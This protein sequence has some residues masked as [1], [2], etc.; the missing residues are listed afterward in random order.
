MYFLLLLETRYHFPRKP[1]VSPDLRARPLFLH[2]SLEESLYSQEVG[3]RLLSGIPALT[4][5]WGKWGEE[6]M[7]RG[8]VTRNMRI[9]VPLLNHSQA[10]ATAVCGLGHDTEPSVIVGRG[11]QSR[12]NMRNGQKAEEKRTFFCASWEVLIVTEDYWATL[13]FYSVSEN[14]TCGVCVCMCCKVYLSFQSFRK[15]KVVLSSIKKNRAS[16][17]MFSSHF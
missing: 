12:E 2:V 16:S 4:T 11:P 13:L 7:I 5:S 9:M 15:Y 1:R 8:L 14:V 3:E 10:M 6:M 17:E